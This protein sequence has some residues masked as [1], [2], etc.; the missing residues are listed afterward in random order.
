MSPK[1]E[2]QRDTANR[3]NNNQHLQMKMAFRQLTQKRQRQ[4]YK[5]HGQ[6]VQHAQARQ[7]DCCPV[8]KA[9]RI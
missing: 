1:A 6:A 5:W 9:G 2:T 3:H 8:E 4:Q 7:R